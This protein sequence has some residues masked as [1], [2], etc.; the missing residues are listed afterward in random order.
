MTGRLGDPGPGRW[1]ARPLRL[2]GRRVD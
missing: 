2:G 1:T